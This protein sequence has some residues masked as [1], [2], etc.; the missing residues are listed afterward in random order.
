MG[1]IP[2]LGFLMQWSSAMLLFFYHSIDVA[3]ERGNVECLEA[4]L[5]KC[6]EVVIVS[7]AGKL[8]Y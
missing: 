5:E 4:L 7:K 2:V 1:L 8:F 3:C 6:A